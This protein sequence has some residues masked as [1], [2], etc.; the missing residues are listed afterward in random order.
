VAHGFSEELIAVARRKRPLLLSWNV[1]LPCTLAT[2]F[3]E[4]FS[5]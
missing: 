4:L 5:F 1:Q 2:L 3:C